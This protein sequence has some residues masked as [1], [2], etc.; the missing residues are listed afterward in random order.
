MSANRS[1]QAAQRRRAGGPEPVAPGRGPQPSINSSQMFSGQGQ[2][3]QQQ[4]Q[5]QIR[6][7]TSGRLAGQQA[8]VQQQQMQQQQ[9]Q[10]QQPGEN[11]VSKITIA[12]AITLTTLRLGKVEMQLYEL[13]HQME[14]NGGQS[15]SGQG[16]QGA[17]GMED[18]VLID[19]N[20]IDSIMSRLESLEK[21]SPT[22]NAVG[23]GSSADITLLKQQF[24]AIKPSIANNTKITTALTKEQKEHKVIVDGLRFEMANTKDLLA[25][26][27]AMS[28][29]NSQKIF[30]IMSGEE[31]IAHNNDDEEDEDTGIHF[32]DVA[33]VD[34]ESEESEEVDGLEIT[35]TSLKGLIEQELNA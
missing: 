27:Q 7:G 16:V 20:L 21:R 11:G 3:Q 9:M 26:L 19:K 25:A 22:N 13:A 24:D 30:Q 23:T 31:V 1:V 28:M 10:Q 29:D 35:G 6:P 2:G 5:Q 18:M 34:G 17:E 14:A 32:S 12:Q 15:F 4:Q 8:Q 33:A